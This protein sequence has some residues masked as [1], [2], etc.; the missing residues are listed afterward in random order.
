MQILQPMDLDQINEMHHHPI[1]PLLNR[2]NKVLTRSNRVFGLDITNQSRR[3]REKESKVKA[4]GKKAANNNDINIIS[5]PSLSIWDMPDVDDDLFVTD[6]IGDIMTN[7]RLDEDTNAKSCIIGKNSDFMTKQKDINARMRIVL[8]DWLVEVHRKFKLL[9]S[10]YFLAVNLLDRF[11]SKQQL[12]RRK[13]QLCGC[14]CLWIASKY[15]EIYAP[16]ND[17]FI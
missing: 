11:L 10:T 8:V 4:K 3:L 14:T 6:Y 7:L 15:Q 1:K 9:P 17:D 16:E 2:K 5:K 13:L 12:H